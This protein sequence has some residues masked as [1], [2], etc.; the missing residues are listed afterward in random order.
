MTRFH[1]WLGKV[2]SIYLTKK[3]GM[4][5]TFLCFHARNHK[6][7][8]KKIRTPEDSV[9][10]EVE[11]DAQREKEKKLKKHVTTL[12]TYIFMINV[13]FPSLV[14]FLVLLL[15]ISFMCA[16]H[17]HSFGIHPPSPRAFSA[18]NR[19][20]VSGLKQVE[21]N[22]ETETFSCFFH[23]AFFF[24]WLSKVIENIFHSGNNGKALDVI[25]PENICTS[26]NSHHTNARHF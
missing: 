4:K 20:I 17:R 7:K 2:S 9:R 3:N 24:F 19:K 15:L 18:Q 11:V 5:R 25:D 14:S 12:C 21:G 23:F 10:V 8:K 1:E 16:S 26:F 13:S 22:S 6:T